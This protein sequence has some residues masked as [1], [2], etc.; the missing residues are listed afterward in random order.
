MFKPTPVL[1]YPLN[2]VG[3]LTYLS[4]TKAGAGEATMGGLRPGASCSRQVA[5]DCETQNH[6]TEFRAYLGTS[7]RNQVPSLTGYIPSYT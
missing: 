6:P 2:R 5:P 7:P 4:H 1:G 3:W